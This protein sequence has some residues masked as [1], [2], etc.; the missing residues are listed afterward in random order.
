MQDLFHILASHLAKI[1]SI[2]IIGLGLSFEL[3]EPPSHWLSNFDTSLGL[4]L[5]FRALEAKIGHVTNLSIFGPH[6]PHEVIVVHWMHHSLYDITGSNLGTI[7]LL[8]A[9]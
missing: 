4:S 6:D 9:L 3:L 7:H 5:E 8:K 2:C 1:H